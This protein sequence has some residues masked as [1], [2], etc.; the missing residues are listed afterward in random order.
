LSFPGYDIEKKVAKMFIEKNIYRA[1]IPSQFD[2]FR[3]M[4]F[5]LWLN[6]LK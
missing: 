6:G 5:D 3:I 2:S 1:H 4:G